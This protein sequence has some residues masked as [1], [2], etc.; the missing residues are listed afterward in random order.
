MWSQNFATLQS[1]TAKSS[2]KTS[3]ESL[4]SCK[5]YVKR[6]PFVPRDEFWGQRN[7]TQRNYPSLSWRVVGLWDQ[8]GRGKLGSTTCQLHR[9]IVCRSQSP[10]GTMTFLNAGRQGRRHPKSQILLMVADLLDCG[11]AGRASINVWCRHVLQSRRGKSRRVAR[12]TA[13]FLVC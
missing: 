2:G 1:T 12:P 4:R 3:K 6:F 9:C 7:G 10:I 11:P 13:V 8:V 5:E